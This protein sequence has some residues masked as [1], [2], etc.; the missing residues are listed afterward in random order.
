VEITQD[1]DAKMHWANYFRNI[2][3]HYQVIIEGWPTN[4]PFANLSKVS[5]ALPDLELLLQKW[6]SGVIHW[7]QVDDEKFQQL[8]EERN[9]KLEN[10]EIVDHRRRTHSDKGKKQAWSPDRSGLNRH[11]KTYK[12]A[13]TVETDNEIENEDPTENTSAANS[14]PVVNTTSGAFTSP[15]AGASANGNP[16]VSATSSTF[17][18]FTNSSAFN[19][20]DPAAFDPIAFDFFNP[21]FLAGTGSSGPLTPYDEFIDPDDL[22]ANVDHIFGPAPQEF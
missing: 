8:L 1:E 20:S 21:L 2:I 4:I 16:G 9:E 13:E 5:S 7:R 10:G 14:N 11:K 17:T 3:Q 18:N 6:Q 22:L 12:S 15:G 19:F